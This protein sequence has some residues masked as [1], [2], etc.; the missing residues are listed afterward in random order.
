MPVYRAGRNGYGW[1]LSLIHISVLYY[2]NMPAARRLAA[3]IEKNGFDTIL[4]P[5]LFPAETLT[6]A[7]KNLGLCVKSYA[8]ATDYT[9]IPFWEETE[10]DYFF[11]PH[12]DLKEEFISKGI[13]KEKLISRQLFIHATQD[14]IQHFDNCHLYSQTGKERSKFH[15]DR[16]V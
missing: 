8:I 1:C 4:M 15:T 3:Y 2:A 5:H 13:P 10:P 7:R 16:C 11:I 12:E 6:A 14:L 9:C